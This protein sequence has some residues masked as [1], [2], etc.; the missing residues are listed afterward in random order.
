GQQAGRISDIDAQAGRTD[1]RN[2]LNSIKSTGTLP[3]KFLTGEL[4][5]L[6]TSDNE[7]FLVQAEQ[8]DPPTVARSLPSDLPVLIL[9]GQKE[10]QIR[11]A[12]VQAVLDGFRQAGN[13]R[14]AAVDLPNV[15]HVFKEVPGQPDPA[16]DY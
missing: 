6:F 2:V 16:A 10:Q 7:R 14:A 9:R 5:S 8:Y 13:T 15:D 3:G 12:D 1:L 11:P 4:Q